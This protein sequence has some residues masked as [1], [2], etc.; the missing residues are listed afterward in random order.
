MHTGELMDLSP[1]GEETGEGGVGMGGRWVTWD[2]S[3][4]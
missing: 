2:G 4:P 1:L 3:F